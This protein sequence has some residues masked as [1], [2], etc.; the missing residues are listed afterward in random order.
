VAFLQINPPALLAAFSDA[1]RA[2]NEA[3]LRLQSLCTMPAEGDQ[4]HIYLAEPFLMCESQKQIDI[5]RTKVIHTI[6]SSVLAAPLFW[7]AV[8]GLPGF[9]VL[10]AL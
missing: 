6:N 1:N 8:R 4:E 9:R 2:E 7:C 5:L 3:L 10:L